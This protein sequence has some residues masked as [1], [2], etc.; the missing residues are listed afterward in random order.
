M[1]ATE[2][3]PGPGRG[4]GDWSIGVYRGPSPLL[5]FPPEAS[6]QP[7]LSAAMVTDLAARFVADPFLVRDSGRWYMFFEVMPAGPRQGVVAL[8]QSEDG[9]HWGYQGVVLREPFH[10]S[11]PH[12]FAWQGGYYMTP[13]T[14]GA[15][16]VRL[17]RADPF[18]A[19]WEPVANLVPGRHAD[20]TVFRAG[21]RWWMFSCTP[22]GK[23]ATLR[24][25]HADA[26]AGPWAEH[27]SSP[28]V[29]GDARLARPAGRVVVWRGELLRFAQDCSE[30]YGKQV[31]ASRLLTLTRT[32]YREELAQAGPVLGPGPHG[33]NS[34]GM[35]HLDAQLAPDGGWLAAVDG[36]RE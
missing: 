3:R 32:E 17:Y 30:R 5:L 15:G 27:P 14:L 13:E 24:L 35:H 33:W 29:R 12:V 10:L 36:T 23:N 1:S 18:P 19:H 25:Y 16:C 26:L 11:Y 4:D 22:P 28:V 6:T 2:E 8:A 21:G 20:P 31:S 7:V 9:R 34:Q